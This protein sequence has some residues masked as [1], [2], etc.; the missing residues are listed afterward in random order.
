MTSFP[1]SL[2]WASM[3]DQVSGAQPAAARLTDDGIS[4]S[5]LRPAISRALRRGVTAKY[6]A[7]VGADGD[8]HADLKALC[9][10]AKKRNIKVEHLIIAFKDAWRELPEARTYPQGTQG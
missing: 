7:T 4:E 10:D 9:R 6:F 1:H 8:L 5:D 2:W 3:S